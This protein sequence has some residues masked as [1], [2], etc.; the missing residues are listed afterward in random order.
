MEQR[1]QKSGLVLKY[2]KR[3]FDGGNEIELIRTIERQKAL[4][5]LQELQKDNLSE[6]QL[7]IASKKEAQPV[8]ENPITQTALPPAPV[9]VPSCKPLQARIF[10]AI[11]FGPLALCVGTIGAV[12]GLLAIVVF[13]HM[14]NDAMLEQSRQVLKDS[15]K[16]F[17]KGVVDSITTPVRVY[18]AIKNQV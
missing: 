14:Q 8:H 4:K 9:A 13:K 2:G 11:V 17:R 18:K 16:T 3:R 6:V 1:E 12:T 5:Q 15:S 7:E 10:E